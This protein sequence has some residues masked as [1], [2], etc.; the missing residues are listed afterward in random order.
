MSHIVTTGRDTR[1]KCHGKESDHHPTSHHIG[2]A[3]MIEPDLKYAV[4]SQHLICQG[5][6]LHIT[7]D[8]TSK[9]GFVED[10]ENQ[11]TLLEWG[12][13]DP[14]SQQCENGSR[15]RIQTRMRLA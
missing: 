9:L 8:S 5:L 10:P 3:T 4:N 15:L 2:R 6:T 7:A 11:K 12:P 14:S 13:I 1:D